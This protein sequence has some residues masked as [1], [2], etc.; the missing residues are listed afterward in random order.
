MPFLDNEFDLIIGVSVFTHLGEEDQFRWLA[1][2]A[3]VIK[4]GGI[5]LMSIQG[6]IVCAINRVD[7]AIVEKLYCD[8]F[9]VTGLNHD[10]RGHVEDESYYKNVL[11]TPDYIFSFW[12]QYFEIVDII[13]GLALPQD[14]VVMRKP[15]P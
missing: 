6:L 15:Y 7:L 8:H 10:L 14:L 5:A 1:E 11:H 4:P 13:P 9:L 3:R 2:L 12:S